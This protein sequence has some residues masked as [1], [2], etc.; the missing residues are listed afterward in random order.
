MAGLFL[1]SMGL[2]LVSTQCGEQ[3]KSA[4][5]PR[6]VY[7]TSRFLLATKKD[8]LLATSQKTYAM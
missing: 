2:D 4:M 1:S 7:S 3:A 5:K 6:N 8:V